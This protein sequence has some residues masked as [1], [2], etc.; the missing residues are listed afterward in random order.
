MTNKLISKK[1]FFKMA[2][3][4]DNGEPI[5]GDFSKTTKQ[6]FDIKK[7]IYGVDGELFIIGQRTSDYFVGAGY[8]Q[9]TGYWNQGYYDFSSEKEAV[10]FITKQLLI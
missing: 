9:T 3:L 2:G 8:D 10:D 5:K 4:N 1:E 6:G 7:K